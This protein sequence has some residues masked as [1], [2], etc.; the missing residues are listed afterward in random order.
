M[1][2][3][4]YIQSYFGWDKLDNETSCY[5]KQSFDPKALSFPIFIKC[6][7]YTVSIE[8][9][10]CFLLVYPTA[11]SETLLKLVIMNEFKY[12]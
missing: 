10:E 11:M 5:Y 6:Y 9:F 4:S 8:F 3:Y 1:N 7:R 12:C 2:D